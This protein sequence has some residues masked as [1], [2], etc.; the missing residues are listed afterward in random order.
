MVRTEAVCATCGAHLG[1]VFDDGPQPTGLRYC[2]NSASL[3]LDTDAAEGSGLLGPA[4]AVSRLFVAAPV[5]DGVRDL[6]AARLPRPDE[7]GVRWVPAHQW[8]VTL[9]FVGEVDDTDEA[10]LVAALDRLDAPAAAARLGP[11][12]SRL[13]RSVVCLPVS[14]LDELAEAVR[15]TTAAVGD[16]TRPTLRRP[17]HPGPP[18]RPGRLRRQRH[19]RRP[20]LRRRRGRAGALDPRARTAG[21][22]VRRSLR[23]PDAVWPCRAPTRL[24]RG[25]RDET[26]LPGGSP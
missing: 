12:V 21:R 10:A 20:R 11:R 9:R 23:V 1:H 3:R 5:P 13:G 24:R 8:H 26:R 15:A 6:L 19:G 4:L 25:R 7:P 18:A 22:R 14:G 17:P 2:M 16:P